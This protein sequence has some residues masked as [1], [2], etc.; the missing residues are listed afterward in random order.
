MELEVEVA[1][2]DEYRDH[3]AAS[4]ADHCLE[5]LGERRIIL[6]DDGSLSDGFE[7]KT[8]PMSAAELKLIA[9]AICS[10]DARKSLRSHNGGNCGMHIHITR[11]ALTQL[12]QG[13]MYE[14]VNSPKNAKLVKAIAR[15]YCSDLSQSN[16]Y[17]NYTRIEPEARKTN[18]TRAWDR[19]CKD[20]K[21][22][23][24]KQGAV[25]SSRYVAVNFTY[26]T[27]ELR[28]TRGTLKRETLL[29]CIEWV[30]A[31]VCFTR[32]GETNAGHAE[33]TQEFIYWLTC[34]PERNSRWGNLTKYLVEKK[35]LSEQYL[36]NKNPALAPKIEEDI[37]CLAA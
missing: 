18:V 17:S 5:V 8:P 29:A 27:V 26:E 6:C 25:N 28:I 12:Q 35:F 33:T 13:K 9:E 36:P 4:L 2:S 32:T 11:S 37:M 3:V 24:S 15:R 19:S 20:P 34:H 30:A 21:K 23:F 7:I 1:D 14:F 16:G 31:L 22:V 10:S